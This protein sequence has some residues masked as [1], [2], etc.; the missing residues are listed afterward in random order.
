MS[1]KWIPELDGL[2]VLMILMVSWYHI[3]QQSWLTPMVGNVSLDY[4]MRS[5]YVW[6]DGTVLLSAFLLYRPYARVRLSGGKMPEI[7]AFYARRIR[8]ILPGYYTILL[9][10]FFGICLPFG[11]YASP[12]YLVKD[13][14]THLTFLFPFFRDTY[15]AT[16]LGAACWT[17]AIEVQAYLLFPWMAR[18]SL[19]RPALTFGSMLAVCLGFRAWCIW[20]LSDFNMVVNQLVNFLD[21]YVIGCMLAAA[22]EYLAD[23]RKQKGRIFRGSGWAATAIF[24]LAFAGLL[25]MLRIQAASSVY[26]RQWGIAG[27]IGS[28]LHMAEPGSNYP[29]I[30]RN[31]MIYR[32]VYAALFGC[33]ILSAPFSLKPLRKL[34]GNRLTGFL[35]GI[36]MNYYLAHQTVIVHM[37]RVGFPASEYEYPNQAGDRPWQLRYTLLA[38]GLSLLAAVIITYAAEKP[39]QRWIDRKK[40]PGRGT[41]P[42]GS[43]QEKSRPGV[44][45]A[46]PHIPPEGEALKGG[47][48]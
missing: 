37:R 3:W 43:A 36:S 42:W 16:P 23:R 31:Q 45:P 33:M 7:P 47:E 19:K 22:Y 48:T 14:A 11:L 38:F 10:T 35:A 18:A 39:I 1:K 25:A 30:Q 44:D 40:S 12:Q 17:L 5:G 28:Q 20:S 24:L 4:L 9:L 32:P 2:R 8:R 26:N 13:L 27:W 21:V 15:L 6:V 46:D 29:V 34:L 41:E